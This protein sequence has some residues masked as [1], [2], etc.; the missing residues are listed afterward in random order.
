MTVQKGIG[1]KELEQLKHL[2]KKI[3]EVAPNDAITEKK[4]KQYA[5][6]IIYTRGILR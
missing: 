3:Q 4:E 2:N 5:R 6:Q 1:T